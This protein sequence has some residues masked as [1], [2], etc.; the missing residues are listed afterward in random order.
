MK[1]KTLL[2][3]TL[4]WLSTFPAMGAASQKTSESGLPDAEGAVGCVRTINTAEYTYASSYHSG[5]SRTLAA[6]GMTP[7]W[8]NPTPEAAGLIDEKLTTGKYSGYVFTY[9]A[10]ATD[11]DAH[12]SAYSLTARPMKWQKGAVNFFTDQTGVIRWT[13]E[14][15]A[16]TA[17]DPPIDSL[18]QGP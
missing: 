16:P 2:A 3:V 8:K 11:K 15:R 18:L 13:K 10:G 14:N 9:H 4:I 12:V 1:I 6:L 17:K 7:G 5:F